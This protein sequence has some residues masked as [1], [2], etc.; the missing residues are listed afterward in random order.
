MNQKEPMKVKI[1][2]LHPDAV[3]PKYAHKGDAGLD[4][5]ATSM[6][7][8]EHGN[9]VY[10]TGLAIEIPETFVGL[11]FPRSSNCKTNLYLTNSVGVIDSGYRGEIMFKYKCSHNVISWLNWLWQRKVLRRKEVNI[12]PVSITQN[13]YK[14]G[15]RVGQLIL[16]KYP[17]LQLREVEELSDTDRGNKG[18]GST[19]K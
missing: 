8:D 5:V 2:K 7:Y 19:G 14:V 15:D 11:V 10:G 1:K 12:K 13:A 3:I 6:K 9:I 4:L 18:Y 17:E 16:V